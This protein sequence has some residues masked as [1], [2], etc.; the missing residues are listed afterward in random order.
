MIRTDRSNYKGNQTIVN[1]NA[2]SDLQHLRDIFVIYVDNICIALFHVRLV[3][4]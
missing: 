4:T 3:G 1:V 2:T